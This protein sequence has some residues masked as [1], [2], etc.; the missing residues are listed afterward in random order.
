MLDRR[1]EL[2]L[3]PLVD[4]EAGRLLASVPEEAR[5]ECWWLVLRDGTPVAG[6]RGGGVTLFTEI[7]LTRPLGRVLRAL[8][9][10]PLVDA[11]DTLLGRY[12]KR[13]GRF[14]PES[15]APR[16]YP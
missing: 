4:E 7:Q 12:R 3:L 10:C 1:E 14:V 16:R 8:R 13:L 5:G 2:A 15:P 9:L 11:L 6:D